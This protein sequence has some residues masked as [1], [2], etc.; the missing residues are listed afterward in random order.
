MKKLLF[1]LPLLLFSLNID[2][3]PCVK[4]YAY[5]NSIIPV[6]KTRAVT[7]SKPGEYI[8]Y[9]EFTGMYVVSSSN[10]TYVYLYN[11]PKIGWFMAALNY[12]SAYGGTYA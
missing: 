4:K 1:F 7:F 3:S 8:F 10:K 9:D 6:T 5:I 11:T 12:E 2:F